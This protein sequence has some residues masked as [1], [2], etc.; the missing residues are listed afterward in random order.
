MGW[1]HVRCGGARRR[2]TISTC[3]ILESR[4]GTCAGAPCLPV[5]DCP[6]CSDATTEA[7]D[8]SP[9][10]MEVISATRAADVS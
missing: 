6:L 3:V 5:R 10:L 7:S 2:R 4:Y 8:E 9:W 1:E